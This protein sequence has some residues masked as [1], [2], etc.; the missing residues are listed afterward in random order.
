MMYDE[1]TERSRSDGYERRRKKVD[2]DFDIPVSEEMKKSGNVIVAADSVNNRNNRNYA[3]GNTID[4]RELFFAIKKRFLIIVAVSLFCG[5]IGFGY[6]RFLITPTY[7]STSSMLVLSKETTLTSLADLQLGTQ[8]TLD[9]Q[10]LIRST[11]VLE[12][13]IE[14]LGLGMMPNGLRSCVTVTN[15]S[16]TRL[17]YLSVNHTDPVLACEIVNE[18]A[19]VSS[20]YIGDK[21]EVIPPKII[22]KGEVPSVKTSPNVLRYTVMGL[23]LGIVTCVGLITVLVLLDDTVKSEDDIMKYLGIP[24][25][26]IVP[27][28]KDYIGGSQKK[29]RRRRKG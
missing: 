6:A 9:Y 21:M 8:L 15:P 27:D 20:D 23:L 12:K 25:L 28:R 14:N 17:L 10:E 22:E 3:A 4:W 24:T 1:M 18:L 29:G 19:A 26:A 16:G 7:T 2:R 11:P 5:C 13:V